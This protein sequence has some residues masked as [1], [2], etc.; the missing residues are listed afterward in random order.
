[1][2]SQAVAVVG[3]ERELDSLER[4]L[5]AV[6]EH[7]AGLKLEGEVGIGKTTLW[8]RVVASARKRS[9][10]VLVSRPVESET[11]LAF[12]ALGD[13]L[14][15]VPTEAMS[16]LPDPQRH[17]LEVA[18]RRREAEGPAPQP[19]AVA[20]GLLGVLRSLAATR[21][22]LLAVDDVQWLDPPS[23]SALGFVARRLGEWSIGLLVAR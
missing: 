20:L 3:R 5:D 22:V 14:E 9:Y 17:A 12:A 4:F 16:G 13:L 19:R 8:K 23:A 18:L 11:Q 1:M 7:P 15:D 6:S 2:S 21:P 10:H